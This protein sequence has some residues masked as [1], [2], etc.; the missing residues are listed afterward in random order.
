MKSKKKLIREKKLSKRRNR[1]DLT[2]YNLDALKKWQK[3]IE[4]E[5]RQFF[6]LSLVFDGRLNALERTKKK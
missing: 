4:K 5:I 6:N 2:L 1:R 3:K